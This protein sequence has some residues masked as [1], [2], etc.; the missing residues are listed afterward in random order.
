MGLNHSRS[1]YKVKK[2]NIV[3]DYIILEESAGSG[4]RGDILKCINKKTNKEYALKM[5][6]FEVCNKKYF[7]QINYFLLAT[8]FLIKCILLNTYQI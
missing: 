5:L 7:K 6:C 1:I 8:L 4:K 2:R 3:R